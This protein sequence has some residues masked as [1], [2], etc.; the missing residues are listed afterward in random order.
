MLSKKRGLESN[1]NIAGALAEA[2]QAIAT[3]DFKKPKVANLANF[4]IIDVISS[5]YF[6][7]ET[8]A[9]DEIEKKSSNSK[10]NEKITCNGVELVREKTATSAK[11]EYIYDLYYTKSDEIHLDM[12]YPNNFEI[13]SFKNFQDV[14]LVD[15]NFEDEYDGLIELF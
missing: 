12:L 11:P 8:N 15:D 6:E 14:D 10:E 3:T 9:R 7:N 1:G 4:N 13:K 2:S 5:E